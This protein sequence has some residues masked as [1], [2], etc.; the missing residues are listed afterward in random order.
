[1]SEISSNAVITLVAA[2][3]TAC[4][5]PPSHDQSNPLKITISPEGKTA[6]NRLIKM[7]ITNTG[8]FPLA[9]DARDVPW[10][11]KLSMTI[12]LLPGPNAKPLEES[13]DIE[14]SIETFAILPGASI[15]GIVDLNY[16]FSGLQS[17]NQTNDIIGFWSY[18]PQA[19]NHS[20]QE[21][22]GGHFV[23]PA[24]K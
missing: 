21:R 10:R 12:V 17:A 9:V 13:Y 3:L 8:R 19:I 16:R 20:A 23:L 6:S 22:V 18:Q 11:V 4:A 2:L 15:S 1:M 7:S 24:Q 14:D 5:S